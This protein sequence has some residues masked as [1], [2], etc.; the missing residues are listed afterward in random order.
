MS[1]NYATKT[2]QVSEMGQTICLSGF[3][4]L[5]V[6][7]PMGPLWILGDVFIGKFYTEFDIG[8]N[9]VGFAT[10]KAAA[11]ESYSLPK[12]NIPPRSCDEL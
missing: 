2:F 1:S 11:S 10:A 4:P 7:P 6:P 5:D 9:R 8:N 3:M 12:H